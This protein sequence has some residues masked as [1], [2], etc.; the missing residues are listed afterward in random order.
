MCC[1][2]IVSVPW[3]DTLIVLQVAVQVDEH[4]CGMLRRKEEESIVVHDLFEV[5][6]EVEDTPSPDSPPSTPS[7]SPPLTPPPNE[8]RNC[9]VEEMRVTEADYDRHDCA[10]NEEIFVKEP[11]LNGHHGQRGGVEDHLQVK[12]RDE[13]GFLRM[14]GAKDANGI[15]C[16]YVDC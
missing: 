9:T 12:D 6:V 1:R 7:S 8:E 13:S 10:E 15:I 4:F 3:R 2:N 5:P 16:V 11:I 14:K